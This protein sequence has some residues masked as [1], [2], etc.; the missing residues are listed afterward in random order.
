ML[1]LGAWCLLCFAFT[2]RSVN[3][4]SPKRVSSRHVAPTPLS[5]GGAE[6]HASANVKNY[7]HDIVTC[8]QR[9]VQGRQL[10]G[11]LLCSKKGDAESSAVCQTLSSLLNAKSRR[12]ATI[13]LAPKST[14]AQPLLARL[15]QCMPF[16]NSSFF[17][18]APPPARKNQSYPWPSIQQRFHSCSLGAKEAS[19]GHHL[20]P[21]QCRH[22]CCWAARS[23]SC[24]SS[25]S[26]MIRTCLAY[27]RWQFR[28]G[29]TKYD[30]P[31]RIVGTS[32][33]TDTSS[34]AHM[35]SLCAQQAPR[36]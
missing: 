9:I 24:R 28:E 16:S 2:R 22:P 8:V 6:H 15:I 33:G 11:L 34:Q 27:D 1:V 36:Y 5:R 32:S 23:R 14:S 19:W 21:C 35:L 30:D 31:I 20:S 26:H 17:L 4:G 7:I 29:S 12:N 10:R 13:E 18:G 25:W 3:Q